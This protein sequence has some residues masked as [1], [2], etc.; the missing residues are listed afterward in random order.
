MTRIQQHRV[1][2][3]LSRLILRGDSLDRGQL[4]VCM[5]ASPDMHDCVLEILYK[6]DTAL[7]GGK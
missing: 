5:E 6:I 3:Y 4:D 7:I 1:R 2:D